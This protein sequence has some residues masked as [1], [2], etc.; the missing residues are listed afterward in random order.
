MS[1]EIELRRTEI[2]LRRTH[3]AE[4]APLAGLR[5]AI[6]SC[7]PL[8]CDPEETRSHPHGAQSARCRRA[9]KVCI[10]DRA[11]SEM[12]AQRIDARQ[13]AIGAMAAASRDFGPEPLA[14]EG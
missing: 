4:K 8:I 6:N 1:A 2:E 7:W 14:A 10:D 12:R 13:S 5:S 9:P 3:V 11:G